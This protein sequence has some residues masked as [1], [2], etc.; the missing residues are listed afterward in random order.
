MA[1]S[2]RETKRAQ[3]IALKEAGINQT[4]I[5]KQLKCDPQ[6]VH[7]VLKDLQKRILF[8]MLLVRELQGRLRKLMIDFLFEVVLRIVD[9][10]QPNSDCS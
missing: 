3:I 10:L 4:H 5:A 8:L 7:R 6:T 1:I 2:P 9:F